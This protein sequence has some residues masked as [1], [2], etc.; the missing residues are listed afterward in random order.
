[1]SDR[2]PFFRSPSTIH[3]GSI[4]DI[5]LQGDGAP[6]QRAHFRGGYLGPTG[7]TVV[8]HRDIAAAAR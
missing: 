2:A 3:I 6:A 4:A 1:M 8:I 5:G 7:I